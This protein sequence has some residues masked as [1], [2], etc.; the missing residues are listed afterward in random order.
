MVYT[1]RCVCFWRAPISA[2]LLALRIRDGLLFG[3]RVLHVHVQVYVYVHAYVYVQVHLHV[4]AH[5]FKFISFTKLT[6]HIVDC[7]SIS[8]VIDLYWKYIL[9][10]R[11]LFIAVFHFGE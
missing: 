1:C 6:V 10:E 5:D 2:F 3:L 11:K 7:L 4:H 9:P 8:S